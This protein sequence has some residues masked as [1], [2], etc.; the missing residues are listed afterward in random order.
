MSGAGVPQGGQLPRWWRVEHG[1]RGLPDVSVAYQSADGL[2]WEWWP[3]TRR[4]HPTHWLGVA[5]DHPDTLT[6]EG[7]RFIPLASEDVRPLL[8]AQT[9]RYDPEHDQL[10]AGRR[11]DAA[12]GRTLDP[13]ELLDEDS[14]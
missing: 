6:A 11:A 12:A 1:E 9:G 13:F 2:W 14:R 8:T 3:E 7:Y 4:L 10:A 5:H